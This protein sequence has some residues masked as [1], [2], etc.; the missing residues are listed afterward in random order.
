VLEGSSNSEFGRLGIVKEIP[1]GLRLEPG[2]TAGL[3]NEISHLK[4]M[5]PGYFSGNTHPFPG[6]VSG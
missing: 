4:T 1:S 6:N 5:F 3:G 2:L